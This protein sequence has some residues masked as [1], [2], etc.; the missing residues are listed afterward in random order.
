MALS[1][2]EKHLVYEVLGIP[3]ATSVLNVN[4]DYGTGSRFENFAVTTAKTEIDAILDAL[5][6]DLEAR[7]RTLLTEW[8]SVSTSATKLR[9]NNANQGV[10]RDPAKIRRLIRERVTKIVPVR[11]ESLEGSSGAIPLG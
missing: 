10:E 1:G 9:A 2:A 4:A 8:S 6:A 11:V 3:N 5:G 7:L